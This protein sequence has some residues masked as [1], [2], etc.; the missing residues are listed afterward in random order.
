MQISD[1]TICLLLQ[2]RN[3]RGLYQLFELYYNPLVL[4][5]DTFLNDVQQSEDLIQDLFVKVWEKEV[6]KDFQSGTI[7]A[8]LYT[9]VR[10]QCLNAIKKQ[11]P[12]KRAYNITRLQRPWEDYDD[13]QD[14]LLRGVE[15]EIEKLPSRSREIV[16]E[17]YLN[18]KQY[19]EVA[20]ELNISLATVKTLLVRSLKVIRKNSLSNGLT[21]LLLFFKKNYFLPK[22]HC[23]QQKLAE[24]RKEAVN[25]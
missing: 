22:N 11:D 21:L 16:T 12:L 2:Q 15:R 24:Y 19:K 3:V 23:K 18:G 5:A 6:F 8:Y 9:S 10:N 4:W 7:K 13:C 20:E 14:E 17:V 25:Q 1:K